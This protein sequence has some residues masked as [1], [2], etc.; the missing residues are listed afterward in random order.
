[1]RGPGP[2]DGGAQK[3]EAPLGWSAGFSYPAL[4]AGNKRQDVGVAR[5]DGGLDQKEG[6]LGVEGDV[7]PVLAR[8]HHVDWRI[9]QTHEEGRAMMR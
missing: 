1:M 9:T 8:Y 2:V 7:A 3:K 6:W 4:V 5:M